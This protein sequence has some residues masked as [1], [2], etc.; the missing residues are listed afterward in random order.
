MAKAIG[1]CVNIVSFKLC[2]NSLGLLNTTETCWFG[3]QQASPYSN[4][5]GFLAYQQTD[6]LLIVGRSGWKS[7]WDFC[8]SSACNCFRGR[9]L[10]GWHFFDFSINQLEDECWLGHGVSCSLCTQFGR[11]ETDCKLISNCFVRG[12]GSGSNTGNW[13]AINFHFFSSQRSVRHLA[14]SVLSGCSLQLYFL[15]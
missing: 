1:K 9:T 4:H 11:N 12:L 13:S 7:G 15:L 3:S 10:I 14:Y 2:C 8:S 5:T 6:V